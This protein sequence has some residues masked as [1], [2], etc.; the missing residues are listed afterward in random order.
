M[1]D[2]LD[3]DVYEIWSYMNFSMS[4]SCFILLILPMYISILL[5]VSVAVQVWPQAAFRR[6]PFLVAE[7]P[8]RPDI[9]D[10]YIL[11]WYDR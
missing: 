11:A 1:H 7:L 8:Q 6:Y 10:L 9:G 4:N 5:H 2:N 3:Q